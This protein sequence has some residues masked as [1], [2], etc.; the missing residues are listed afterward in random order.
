MVYRGVDGFVSVVGCVFDQ[1]Y[2]GNGVIHFYCNNCDVSIVNSRV[3]GLG[4]GTYW[5]S[6][7]HR[8]RG[9][10]AIIVESGNRA[11]ILNSYIE[12]RD[13]TS[14]GTF[15]WAP[16]NQGCG[17]YS[18]SVNTIAS[19]NIFYGTWR[20][21]NMPFGS[22]ARNNFFAYVPG[23]EVVGGALGEGSRSGDPLFI[24][25]QAPLL[26]L[27]SPCVNGGVADAL[28]NDLDGTRN[29]IGPG[30][31]CLFDPTGWTTDKPVVISFDVGPQQLLRGVDTEV[32]LS[33]GL[34]VGGR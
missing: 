11:S 23:G 2:S 31:G 15:G 17:I 6:P 34:G 18:E 29:D 24:T 20:G 13:D 14:S 22:V 12:G 28:F 7:F 26:Q 9:G 16:G 1:K 33:R 5:E 3:L 30:G 21:A 19:N 8:F 27:A 4:Y 25:G 10:N 32:K